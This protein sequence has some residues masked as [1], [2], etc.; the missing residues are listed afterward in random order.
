MISLELGF[1][2][3]TLSDLQA[4]VCSVSAELS[5]GLLLLFFFLLCVEEFLIDL[6]SDGHETKL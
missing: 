5:A 2:F 6:E 3:M 1:I 4:F